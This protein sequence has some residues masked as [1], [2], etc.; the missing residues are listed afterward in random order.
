MEAPPAPALAA[1]GWAAGAN[2][3]GGRVTGTL[4]A[5][6]PGRLHAVA[7]GAKL[8]E[9]ARSAPVSVIVVIRPC[10]MVSPFL[11]QILKP[12]HPADRWVAAPK[13]G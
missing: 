4:R 12:G 9:I 2:K 13:A 3:L 6:K 7:L 8:V 1:C 11:F 10:M 5:E